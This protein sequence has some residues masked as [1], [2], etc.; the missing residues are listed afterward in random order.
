MSHTRI[1]IVHAK[2]GKLLYYIGDGFW[3]GRTS[4]KKA[5][6]GLAS[7]KYQMWEAK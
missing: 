1:K 3:F 6:D 4:E 2:N 5:L 7:G